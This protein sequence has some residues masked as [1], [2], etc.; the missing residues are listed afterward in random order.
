ML[1]S[2][3]T[4][5]ATVER[6]GRKNNHGNKIPDYDNLLVPAFDVAGCSVQPST[7]ARNEDHRE[8]VLTAYVIYGPA[9]ADIRPRDRVAIGGNR[10]E[11]VDVIVWETGVLDHVEARANRWE[12]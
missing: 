8:A 7:G 9:G 6:P 2:F 10:Y 4:Q 3:A 5:T 1:P 12:G 11:V